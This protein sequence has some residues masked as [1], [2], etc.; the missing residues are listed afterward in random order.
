MF[1]ILP[2]IDGHIAEGRTIDHVYAPV[3]FQAE[4]EARGV[5]FF[6]H[7]AELLIIVDQGAIEWRWTI[8]GG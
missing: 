8:P 7:D 3:R 1:S 6:A 5:A 2:T 4:I